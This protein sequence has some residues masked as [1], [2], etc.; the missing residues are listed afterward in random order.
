MDAYMPYIWLSVVILSVIVEA[1]TFTLV[2][3]WFIPAALISMILAFCS[4]DLWIQL[5]VFIVVSL[6]LIIF[7]KPIFKNVF[8]VK[9]IATNADAVIGERAVVIE[10]ID[11]LAGRGQV[12]VKGQIWTARASDKDARYEKD[13]VLNVVAI[14]GVKLICKK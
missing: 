1:S 6:A 9:P 14:E 8:G 4:V 13:E 11:N 7:M 3:V 10:P 12:K 2:S 5:V